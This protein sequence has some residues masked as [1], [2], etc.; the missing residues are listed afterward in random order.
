MWRASRIA[1][2]VL[3][4]VLVA[5]FLLLVPSL[6]SSADLFIATTSVMVAIVISSLGLV[7]GRAGMLS[8]C[9]MAF[10]AVGAWIF[11][12]L[13]VHASSLSFYVDLLLAGLIT[14][15]I[16]LLVGLPALRLRGVLLGVMTLAFAVTVTVVI[17]VNN[18]P[19]SSSGVS[20]SRP[21]AVF[22][23]RDYFW[24]CSAIFGLLCMV[25]YGVA[26]TPLGASWAAIRNSE[27]GTAALGHSVARAKTSAFI[28]SAFMAGIAGALFV[29]QLGTITIDS[30]Q[31]VASL[32][33]FALAVMVGARYPE[34]ALL[35]GALNGFMPR[36]LGDLSI[37]QDWGP[38]LFAF[39]AIAGLKGGAGA[40]EALRASLRR[41]LVRDPPGL[42]MTRTEIASRLPQRSQSAVRG[43]AALQIVGLT[44]KYGQVV[45]LNDVSIDVP[46]GAVL[47]LIGPNG[48]GKTSLVDAVSGFLPNYDGDVLLGGRNL[49]GLAPHRRAKAG[50]RRSFQQDRTVGELTVGQYLR[51][52]GGWRPSGQL[53]PSELSALLA[54]F[55]CP[56]PHQRIEGLD[57]GTRRLVE[58]VAAVAAQPEVVL[59]DEPAAGL[60]H[61]ESAELAARIASIPELFGPAVLVIEHDMEL[62]QAACSEVTVLDFGQVIA[63][64]S[65]REALADSV[66]VNAYL[67]EEVAV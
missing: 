17:T 35:G 21:S 58:V 59:L 39:G 2:P 43:A 62:V 29:G 16:G 3:T 36:I 64:G 54:Y 32:T 40:A 49:N 66:V 41:L 48:A 23:D 65:P 56:E 44:V 8:L 37:A 51:L 67:G 15:P 47:G 24:F 34:G 22:S 7:T 13:Q 38:V 11:L 60:A 55:G 46:H 45:A 33:F 57:T 5:A 1:G 42:E 9:Q 28:L 30:F 25:V 31:P 53:K 61:A 50:L 12:W 18:F 63:R 6:L 52:S 10:A 19:G 20:V 4:V 27:R 14:A 26:R